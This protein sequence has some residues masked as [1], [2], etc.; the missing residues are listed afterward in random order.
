MGSYSLL[1]TSFPHLPRLR[2]GDVDV[3]RVEAGRLAQPV[4]PL[5]DRARVAVRLGELVDEGLRE[6]GQVE[7]LVEALAWVRVKVRV[8]VRVGVGVGVRVRVRVRVRG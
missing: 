2:D 1:P 4:G 3:L 5:V 8:R 6:L 7:V